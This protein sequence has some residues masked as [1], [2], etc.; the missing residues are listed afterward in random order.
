MA[1]LKHDLKKSINYLNF[2]GFPDSGGRTNDLEK[3]L[4]F[5]VTAKSA[6]ELQLLVELGAL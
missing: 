3:L 5:L 4:S 2:S 6:N 1:C